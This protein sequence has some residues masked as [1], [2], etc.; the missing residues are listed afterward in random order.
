M[1]PKEQRLDR[2]AFAAAYKKGRKAHMPG[3]L[4][5]FMKASAYKAAAVVGKKVAKSA[6]ARNLLRRRLYA[7]LSELIMKEEIRD[8]H[9]IMIAKPPLS[10]YSYAKLRA[11]AQAAL[12][13]IG[14]MSSSR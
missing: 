3:L 10:A 9:I 8:G 13:Q 12:V 7:A 2:V 11:E 1:L 5:V 6:V 14:N 4:L